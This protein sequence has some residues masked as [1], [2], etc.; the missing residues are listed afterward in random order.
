MKKYIII[1]ICVLA[2]ILAF[3]FYPQTFTKKVTAMGTDVQIKTK[4]NFANN[5]SDDKVLKNIETKIV[6]IDKKVNIKTTKSKLKKLKTIDDL[7]K[8]YNIALLAN[9]D[10][11]GYFNVNYGKDKI[12][13]TSIAKSYAM[14]QA[15]Q[16]AKRDILIN[17]FE[18]FVAVGQNWK[19]DLQDA[20]SGDKLL[21]LNVSNNSVCT[22]GFYLTRNDSPIINPLTGKEPDDTVLSCTAICDNTAL[23]KAYAIG[24][25]SSR[26][27][28]Q[29][30]IIQKLENKGV[31]VIIVYSNNTVYISEAVK[32]SGLKGQYKLC[33]K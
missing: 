18:D 29:D 19:V 2:I 16:L 9:K 5:F 32:Y 25:Y 22:A 1:S 8:I 28:A 12:N 30:K 14:Y 6:E 7:S 10:T 3:L 23:A 31:R 4:G 13:L 20:K 24:L 26:G 21:T 27:K 15:S 17:S 11:N 33:E